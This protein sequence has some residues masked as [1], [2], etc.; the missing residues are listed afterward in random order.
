MTASLAHSPH[1][2]VLEEADFYSRLKSTVDSK[3]GL[4]KT[5]RDHELVPLWNTGIFN[6]CYQIKKDRTIQYSHFSQGHLL[7]HQSPIASTSLLCGSTKRQ[8]VF[9]SGPQISSMPKKQKDE[10]C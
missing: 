8:K 9:Y 4:E 6:S 5:I 2:S 1:D 7:P 10:L 3:Q